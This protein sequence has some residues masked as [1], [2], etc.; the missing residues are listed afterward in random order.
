MTQ[1]YVTMTWCCGLKLL[2]KFHQDLNCFGWFR[3]NLELVWYILVWSNIHLK[4]LWKFHQDPTCFGCFSDGLELVWYGFDCNGLVWFETTSM[5]LV[6]KSVG[7][8]DGIVNPI[9]W[10]LVEITP[11]INPTYVGLERSCPRDS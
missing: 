4:V 9:Y 7:I 11:D 6:C 2:W 8:W 1:I 10:C 3:R 5:T